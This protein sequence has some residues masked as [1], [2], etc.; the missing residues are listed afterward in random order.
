MI[1]N[2]E[3]AYDFFKFLCNATGIDLEA[4][5]FAEQ[6]EPSTI[7]AML[8]KRELFEIYRL[9]MAGE[10]DRAINASADFLK[11]CISNLRVKEF[12]TK[13]LKETSNFYLE[14]ARWLEFYDQFA[15]QDRASWQQFVKSIPLLTNAELNDPDVL[16]SDHRDISEVEKTLKFMSVRRYT[17]TGNIPIGSADIVVTDAF[18]MCDSLSSLFSG[19]KTPSDNHIHIT[20]M[21]KLDIHTWMSY[22]I[23]AVQYHD[24]TWLADDGYSYANPRAKEGIAARG[25][26]RIREEVIN[27]SILPYEWLNWVDEQRTAHREVTRTGT[28]AGELYV[29]QITHDWTVQ[30]K[31]LSYLL[32]GQLIHKIITESPSQEINTFTA[33]AMKNSK[34]LTDGNPTLI[35]E[36]DNLNKEFECDYLHEQCRTYVDELYIPQRDHNA[37]VHLSTHDI[38]SRLDGNNTLCTAKQYRELIAWSVKEDERVQLQIGLDSLTENIEKQRNKLCSM[39][40]SNLPNILP[41]LF[42]GDNVYYILDDHK[43]QSFGSG[44]GGRTIYPFTGD[45]WSYGMKRIG[46]N[47]CPN[48][49]SHAG[50]L[51]KMI[52]ISVIHYRQLMWLCGTTDR[53]RLPPYYRNFMRQDLI[54]YHGNTLLD[55]VNPTFTLNDPCSYKHRNGFGINIHL[56]GYCMNRLR[57]QNRKGETVYIH[58]SLNDANV[59]GF[60]LK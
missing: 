42:Y 20:V 41:Y 36:K 54:P 52:G 8:R 47:L 49:K 26:A 24:N 9:I 12:D 25:S 22:F 7:G 39:I 59:N 2:K 10:Y 33:F 60:E 14:A 44:A 50:N 27:K 19:L 16:Q 51:K 32:F 21:L 56:C 15:A 57:K 29:K 40:E 13:S 31:I 58:F 1:T 43:Y 6:N 34:L 5:L 38:I 48:C 18:V 55:N 28:H 53:D 3:Q 11:E 30:A 37:L 4:L 45:Y 23:V 35:V 46:E 17:G